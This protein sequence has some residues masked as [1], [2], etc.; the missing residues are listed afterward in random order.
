MSFRPIKLLFFIGLSDSSES[1]IL[2]RLHGNQWTEEVFNEG[3]NMKINFLKM[4]FFVIVNLLAVPSY[5]DQGNNNDP[6]PSWNNQPIK[7]EI[8]H[9]VQ[10]VVDRNNTNYVAQEDRIA[11]IDNDGTLWVEHPLYSQAIFALDRIKQLAPTHPEWKNLEPYKTILS[12]NMEAISHFTAQDFEKIIAETHAGMT[13]ETF[14]SMVKHWLETAISPRFKYPY[15]NLIYQPMLEVINYL[16]T[17]GFK[18]YIVSGGGQEFIRAYGEDD[19]GIPPEQTIG[20]AGMTKYTYQNGAPVLIKLSKILLIDDN[21]GKPEAIN[22][23][24]GK[25]PIIAFG[26]SDGDRQM[27]EWTQSRPGAHFMALVHHDDA[28]REYAYGPNTKVGTFSDSLM[29]EANKQGWHVISM[30]QDWKII[31]PFEKVKH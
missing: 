13:V 5:A 20:S 16:R 8:I 10:S 18:I 26:N 21:A 17:N 14:H 12:G 4:V 24:V 25:K 19:Y 11:T 28:K 2:S 29:A 1:R 7:N 3:S 6:L 22:L 15:I 23:L 27:L 9:F 31:F 30:Q